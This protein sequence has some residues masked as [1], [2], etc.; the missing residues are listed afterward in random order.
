M[1]NAQA[2]LI[3]L[4]LM[5]IALALLTAIRND[6]SLLGAILLLFCLISY[7]IETALTWKADAARKT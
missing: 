1:T 2:R 7:V 4:A 6:F 3:S 5:A